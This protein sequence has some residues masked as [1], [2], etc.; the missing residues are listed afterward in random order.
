MGLVYIVNA[1]LK[2]DAV[3]DVYRLY[4]TDIVQ[5]ILIVE[6]SYQKAAKQITILHKNFIDIPKLLSE[7]HKKIPYDATYQAIKVV[8]AVYV[9]DNCF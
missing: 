8:S 4:I 5:G 7:Q 6:F 1:D 3:K 9:S 2:Y